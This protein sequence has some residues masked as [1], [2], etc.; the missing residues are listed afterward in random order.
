MLEVITGCMYSGK[1]TTFINLTKELQNEGKNVVIL[2]PI[3]DSRYSK[4]NIVSHDGLE[5]KGL[6]IDEVDEIWEFIDD[7]IDILAIDEIQFFTWDIVDILNEIADKGVH[8]IVAGVDLDFKGKPFGIM[9]VLLAYADKVKKLSSTC[10]ICGN[11]ASRSQRLV[12]GQPAKITDPILVS[13][14]GITYESRCRIHH[15]IRE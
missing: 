5:I 3:Q 6:A 13:A 14:N 7:D 1:T 9:P 12:H 11:L 10:A 4:N 2:K 15:E 8:V